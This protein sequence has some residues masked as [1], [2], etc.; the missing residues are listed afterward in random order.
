MVE[1]D[2]PSGFHHSMHQAQGH[3][4]ICT[5]YGPNESKL[6]IWI[7]ED[8]GTDNWILKHR[9]TTQKVFWSINIRFGFPNFGDECIVITQEWNLIFFIGKDGIIIAYDMDRRIVRVIPAH[10]FRYGSFKKEFNYKPYYLP[11]VPLFSDSL[12]EH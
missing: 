1:I 4:C 10:V 9:V 11:Y 5:I 3:L 7:L 8:C 12:A 2:R 6:S